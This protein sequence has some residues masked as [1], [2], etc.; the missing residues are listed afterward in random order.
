MDEFIDSHSKRSL[1]IFG[2]VALTFAILLGTVHPSGAE[3]TDADR[4]PTIES[5]IASFD[6]SRI[7]LR[8]ARTELDAA[9][10][11]LENERHRRDELER[12]S[13]D[14]EQELLEERSR[15]GSLAALAYIDVGASETPRSETVAN[16]LAGVASGLRSTSRAIT[17]LDRELEIAQHRVE[18]ADRD[19][20][21][22]VAF[23]DEQRATTREA[24]ST[25][26][27]A[28][29][30]GRGPAISA[31]ALLAAIHAAEQARQDDPGCSVS[32]ALVLGA[33]RI[34][35]N[36]GVGQGHDVDDAGDPI[37]SI[38]TTPGADSGSGNT[39]P[40]EPTSDEDGRSGPFLLTSQ[41][42]SEHGHDGDGDGSVHIE[43]LFDAA[44][45]W[46]ISL[47]AT[48]GRLDQS[49]Q[50]VS[51][52]TRLTGNT[53]QAKAIIGAGRRFARRTELGLGDV[54]DDPRTSAAMLT[55]S[56]RDIPEARS[57]ESIADLLEWSRARL[58]TPYSQ[59][60][61]SDD[62]P[63]DPVCPPGT[64]RF[65]NGFFDCSGFVSAAYAAVGMGLPTTTDSMAADP[66]L[67]ATSISDEVD[68]G[69]IAP[70]DILLMDGHVAIWSGDGRIIHASGGE[71]TEEQLP[72][73]VRNGVFSV[74]RPFAAS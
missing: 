23:L 71:L 33:G 41:P 59:C 54:P 63:E 29:D 73:W 22:A 7:D 31:P 2:S 49:D 74:L 58:G 67:M 65:G 4:S 5:L 27:D 17:D 69:S 53:A 47:C 42:I 39:E 12:R 14:L 35:S 30:D 10:D 3:T 6:R 52:I 15:V 44:T 11:R 46:T 18:R 68:E 45:T 61:T 62:R 51:A 60:L 25:L 48:G 57:G 9:A 13:G 36:S 50:L 21:R 56:R 66:G 70:G 72:E 40:T 64:D 32:P 26:E 24:A 16:M 43:N 20:G 19:H 38:S 8:D 28:I 37:P 55:L 34:L 1:Q